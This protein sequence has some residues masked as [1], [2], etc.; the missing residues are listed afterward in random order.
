MNSVR[1]IRSMLL[2][3]ALFLAAQ[4]QALEVQVKIENL[5]P[6]GGL[7]FT[8]VWV[9]FHDGNFDVYDQGS[10]ASEGLE[11]FAEDGDFAALR[12]DFA[13]TSGLDAVMVNPEGFAGAP[14]FD[15]GLAS[16]EVFDLDPVAQQYFSYGTM[17][18]PSN[19]AFV[20][21]DDPMAYQLF[22]D[23]GEFN[24]PISFVVYGSQVLDA[25]T[26][27][28]T[29]SD[30]A[31]LNQ[32]AP[33]TGVT[34]NDVIA[35]HPGFNGSAGNPAATPVNILGATLPPGT[36][37]DPMTGDFTAGLTP[38]MRITLQSTATTVR[39][40]VKNQAPTGGMFLTPVWLGVHDGSFDLFNAGDAA[41]MGIERMAE[42]GDFA[43]L[44]ADF[45]AADVGIGQ[46]VLN[47]EGFAG[48]PLFDPGFSTV[49]LLQLDASQHRYLSYASMLVPSNDAFIA[50]DNPMAY[51]LFDDSGNFTG[52]VSVSISG[53][54]VWDAGTEAN[55][56][57]D[58]AFFD[59]S[60]PNTGETTTD[61]IGLHPGLNGSFANPTGIPQN[62][63][64]GTNGPG[65]SFDETAADFSLPGSA[66]AEIRIS[67]VVDGGHSGSWYNPAKSG[68]GLVLEITNDVDGSGS[69][70]MVSWYHYQADGSGE[71]LWL[72]GVGPVVGDTA[73]VDVVQTSGA[74]FGEGFNTD[75]VVT[76][77]WGQ[78]KIK[79]DSCTSATLT[80]DSVVDG[81]GSGMEPLNR[82]TSGPT[83]FNGACQP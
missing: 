17:I 36:T 34:T 49:G 50:N 48:A 58:A 22:N 35:A 57:S 18:L 62:I 60:A 44:A 83:G 32:T 74:V 42:D 21:N 27:E 31:F 16:Y 37:L 66:V 8:P 29:E 40:S 33:N 73:I 59:Q 76:T 53:Q 11:R 23:A 43:A 65:I 51:P 15:P 69:R 39:F 71:Q 6:E 79:F 72:V 78:V 68:H 41:S 61:V 28:N 55:T 47:P 12:N 4:S 13:N 1:T 14:V 25:G 63:L 2:P 5:S 38:I 19:D 20:G 7:Y 52:P 64:G 45:E 26:E 77:H 70:A 82:L 46:V 80:Y 10:T 56:E 54:Q 24:G 75:D 30:V 3:T 9:G 81:Y 67:A